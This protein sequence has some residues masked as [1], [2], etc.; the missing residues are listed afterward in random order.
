MSGGGK[1]TPR[2]A[3]IGMMYLFYTALLAL[4]VSAEI[5]SAFALVD[6]SLRKTNQINE[7]VISDT[8]EGFKDALK[9]D[10]G[11]APIL[12]TA[13]QVMKQCDEAYGVVQS[14]KELFVC[15]LE[16]V[17]YD[18]SNPESGMQA[19]Y[20]SKDLNYENDKNTVYFGDLVSKKDDNNVGG[21]I[22]IQENEGEHG[23]K[24]QSSREDL[25]AY[26]SDIVN[27]DTLSTAGE[28]E[29][30]IATITEMLATEDVESQEEPGKIVPWPAANFE[31]L[32]AAGVL[33]LMTKMQSDVRNVEASMLQYL[34][35][36]IGKA[37]MKFNAIKAVVTAP[38]NYV[39]VGEPFKAEIFIAAYD[40]TQNPEILVGGSPIPVKN[41]VG[42]YTG[43]TQS[44]GPHSFSGVVKLKNKNT[45]EVKDYPFK[46]DYEVGVSSLSVSPTKMNVLYIG[47][48]NPIEITSSG[49]DPNKLTPSIT[50]GG[51]LQRGA[52]PGEYIATVKAA[53]KV[54]ISVSANI[55]GHTKSLGT[56]EF[57]VK[58]VPDPVAVVGTDPSNRRGGTIS[59]A[60]LANQAG[61]KADLEN[62]DF[63]LKFT[64]VSFTVSANVKGFVK[65]E[66][67]KSAA[68]TPQQKALI[69]SLAPGS[70][71][72][73][74]DIKAKG[75]DGSIRDLGSIN[76][77]LK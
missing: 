34:R 12:A 61:V 53:G 55:D 49:V 74:D 58:R 52:K 7:K 2:Q 71:V 36:L 6:S 60:T 37:D 65:D 77:K 76:F 31:H 8:H 46:G 72:S 5:L 33:S 57:R 14:Y 26:L 29:S 56:R 43:N 48:A 32:P 38:S 13:E 1:E 19:L 10:P 4:N 44:P 40:S 41:G 70:R 3:M 75:P 62:F 54:N 15:T 18:M 45:G 59:K 39:Q 50:G 30:M 22:F 24:V 51:S 64:V 47:V 28:K 68:F 25:K 11:V 73:I 69:N 21:Q 20:A 67:S 27:K 23:K 35:G 17:T 63:D 16:G 42:T 66:P 9:N